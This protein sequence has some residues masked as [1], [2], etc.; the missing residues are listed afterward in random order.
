[1]NV[2]TFFTNNE[3]ALIR[4]GTRHGAGFIYAGV[5]VYPGSIRIIQRKYGIN[6]EYREIM[7]TYE[8]TFGGLVLIIEGGEFGSEW[9]TGSLDNVPDPELVPP[10]YYKRLAFQICAQV[11][12][13]YKDAY[14]A[15]KM[16]RRR[17]WEDPDVTME[18]CRKFF[19]SDRFA[20][21]CP[22]SSAKE[23][24]ALIEREAERTV[25]VW[26]KTDI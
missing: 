3:G 12:T 22:D 18:Q 23:I 8:S 5:A 25:G 2:R 17:R 19:Y 21:F 1:M 9:Y 14:I 4:I 13:D 26:S 16:K 6:I 15:K 24:I 10:E 20:V 7:E 11:A